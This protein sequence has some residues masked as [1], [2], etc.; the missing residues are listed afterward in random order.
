[1]TGASPE[2]VRAVISQRGDNPALAAAT[3][4]ALSAE[5][6]QGEGGRLR[7]VMAALARPTRIV[8]GKAADPTLLVDAL[9][10]EVEVRLSGLVRQ[11][12]CLF[13]YLRL[14]FFDE[15]QSACHS[16]CVGI[17]FCELPCVCGVGGLGGCWVCCDGV[18]ESQ[19]GQLKCRK[20]VKGRHRYQGPKC[21]M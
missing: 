14:C 8:R 11:G 1:M 20:R 9:K 17:G 4:R 5:W 13:L 10:F 2:A 7:T 16:M 6:A 21:C 3:S 12:V 15:A 19:S 18:P